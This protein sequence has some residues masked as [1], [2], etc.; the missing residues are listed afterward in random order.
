[1][2]GAPHSLFVVQTLVLVHR[3]SVACASG[4]CFPL[5]LPDL[6]NVGVWGVAASLVGIGQVV[7]TSPPLRASGS[8]GGP[9]LVSAVWWEVEEHW[10]IAGLVLGRRCIAGLGGGR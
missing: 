6:R 10:F 8:S 1:M 7:C 2:F 4:V 9:E 3:H 5:G